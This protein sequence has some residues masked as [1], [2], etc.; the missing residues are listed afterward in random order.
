[1]QRLPLEYR[2]LSEDGDLSQGDLILLN[3]SLL[4]LDVEAS[5]E[6]RR[7]PSNSFCD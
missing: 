6:K 7:I 3:R 2:A 5:S 4:D 1:M